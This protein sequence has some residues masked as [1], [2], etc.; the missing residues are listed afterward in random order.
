M[1][2]FTGVVYR[3]SD[4]G[5]EQA[6]CAAVWNG[7]KPNRFPAVIVVA[8]NQDDVV[9][10]VALAREEGLTVGI[11]SGGHSWV[12]NAVR[13]GGLLLDLSRLTAVNIDPQ[14]TTAVIEPAVHG[15]DLNNALAEHGLYFPVG[16]CPTVA[17][18]GFILGGG[19][20]LN[21][22][23]VGPAAFSLQAVD[24]VTADGRLLHATDEENADIL[25]AA[26]GSGPGFFAVVTRLYLQLHRRPALVASTMQVH[27]I[28]A[29]DEL[30]PWLFETSAQM[31]QAGQPL[32]LI[33]IGANPTAPEA[34]D[35]V[36]VMSAMAL[37]DDLDEARALL[38]PLENA[39]GLSA[40]L[41]HQPVRESSTDEMYAGL[42]LQYPEGYRYLADS[43][44]LTEP[45]TGEFLNDARQII[46]TLPTSR[47]IVWFIPWGPRTHPN[48]AF[49]LQSSMSF[50]IYAVYDDPAD[51]QLMRNWH[52]DALAS[53][54]R[55]TLGGGM[56]NDSNLFAHPMAVLSP[57]N[58]ARLETLRATYDPDGRFYSYPTPLP[59]AR[60]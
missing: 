18:A 47:S 28:T 26:R 8:A 38:A 23:V 41:H 42:D 6:R 22:N 31:A 7:L 39:P 40:A 45:I 52:N 48:A 25:W 11:R 35:P 9:N 46:A 56:V 4:D 57:D 51:D 21:G 34:D 29:Y 16:S 3:P 49:S 14:A 33:T 20:G 15:S 37:A 13:D 55:Y 10:A 50:Q 30:L 27:P 19:F 1:T 53:I 59:P 36:I 44:W 17:V 60:L 24:V 58:A 32:P 54:D 5:Y 2:H 43:L 12:G